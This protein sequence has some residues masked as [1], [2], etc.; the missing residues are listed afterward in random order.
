LNSTLVRI[1]SSFNRPS[2]SVYQG[3]SNI[4]VGVSLGSTKPATV[5]VWDAST[6]KV[7]AYRSL[8]QLLGDDYKL[9]NR[10]RRQDQRTTHQRHVAQKRSASTQFG[11]SE[12]GQYV[13]RLLAKAIIE[14]ATAYKAS[15]VALPKLGQVREILQ[16]E[17]QA[18]A[19][20][21]SPGCI[22]G[23][24]KYAKQYRISIHRWSHGRLI[25]S[26]QSQ[27]AK[28]GIACEEALQPLKGSP[29][30]KAREVAI[31]AYQS[32]K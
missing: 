22:E 28:I 13:D 6:N 32:R 11:T 3:Q 21:K 27:A 10:Q 9:L 31:T 19:E 17:I 30:E 12:L 26:I 23:Q 5:A 7:M 1:N 8:K 4:V 14:V 2:R 16:S 15:S 18:R 24:Q 25:E 29:Q 20:Q